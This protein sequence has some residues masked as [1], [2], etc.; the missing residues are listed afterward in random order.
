MILPFVMGEAADSIAGNA[1]R[2]SLAALGFIVGVAAVVSVVAAG[3]GLR[4][5]IVKEMGS[6]GRPTSLVAGADWQ[7]LSRTGWK[8][9][10][11]PFDAQDIEAIR[12]SSKGVTG[13]SPVAEFR[14]TAA[15]GRRT[16]VARIMA[17]SSDY[18]AME[19]LRLAR[20][21]V[22]NP[23]DD[24]G[25]RRAVV[26]GSDL[27]EILF[28]AEDPVGRRIE[29]GDFGELEVIGVLEREEAS[30]LQAFSD[31]DSTNNGSLFV[32]FSA[33]TRFGGEKSAYSLRIEVSG[34]EYVEGVSDAALSALSLRHGTWDGNPKF[35]IESGKSALAEMDAMTGLVTAL[36]SAVA[37]ISLVVAGIGVMNVMLISVKERTREIGTRKAIGA[38]ASW[39]R[40]QFL[41]EAL[42]IC[43]GGSLIGVGAASAA[44]FAVQSAMAWGNLVPPATPLWAL[45]G[46]A[47]IAVLFGFIPARRAS[48]LEAAEALRYE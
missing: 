47:L 33:A 23:Q 16:R 27:S 41:I 12:A 36:I 4:A 48:R 46:S 7:Y 22:F 30:V 18:F 34:A 14:F 39:I 38:K 29:I 8:Q 17:V 40:A 2:A 15:N 6:F 3:Q 19:G 25:L 21:R 28:G 5:L 45:A 32:P 44:A 24:A 9:R 43:S 35:R 11:E 1:R 37:G 26:L 13:V 42:F 10:P 31:Y 20:G